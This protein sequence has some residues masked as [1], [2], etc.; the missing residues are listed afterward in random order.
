VWA[1]LQQVVFEVAGARERGEE[2]RQRAIQISGASIDIV[3]R[4][5]RGVRWRTVWTRAARPA[6]RAE[7]AGCARDDRNAAGKVLATAKPTA[8][9]RTKGNE[10]EEE[11]DGEQRSGRER[12]ERRDLHFAAATS[13]PVF[14]PHTLLL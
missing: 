1:W 5:A 7:A 3:Q 11:D 8:T 2:R 6:A 14:T 9:K 13:Q 4:F 12:C 10:I